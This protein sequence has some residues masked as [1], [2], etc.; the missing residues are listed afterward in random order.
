MSLVQFACKATAFESLLCARNVFSVVAQCLISLSFSSL[1]V[2]GPTWR[3]KLFLSPLP[4][5]RIG[6]PVWVN[7]RIMVF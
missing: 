2:D 3:M 4:V 1:C 5:S 7:V 6:L